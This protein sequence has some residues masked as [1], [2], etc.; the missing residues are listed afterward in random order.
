[1]VYTS[2]TVQGQ[3]YFPIV[4][5]LCTY[6]AYVRRES[7]LNFSLTVMI[8]TIVMVAAFKNLANLTNAYGFAVSTVMFVTTTLVAIQTRYIKHLPWF[9]AV[10]FFLVCLSIVDDST[11][12]FPGVLGFRVLRWCVLCVAYD[13]SYAYG[14]C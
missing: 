5:W 6:T 14:F 7:S 12:S 1:M 3:V 4:N 10:G 2:E 8:G 13:C 11:R 9:V